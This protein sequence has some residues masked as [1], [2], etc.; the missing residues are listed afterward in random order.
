MNLGN[1]VFFMFIGRKQGEN[2]NYIVGFAYA[3]EE[4][5][6][7]RTDETKICSLRVRVINT[8][9]LECLKCT[10]Y[11]QEGKAHKKFAYF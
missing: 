1:Q 6:I 9:R 5:E 8:L 2:R 10:I 11:I 7:H 3:C 4:W